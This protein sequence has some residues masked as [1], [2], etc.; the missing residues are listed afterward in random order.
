MIMRNVQ[1]F[2]FFRISFSYVIFHFMHEEMFIKKY[3]ADNIKVSL[4]DL[5]D[6]DEKFLYSNLHFKGLIKRMADGHSKLINEN[7]DLSAITADPNLQK[8]EKTIDT[9][10][11][12]KSQRPFSSHEV[13]TMY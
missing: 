6:Q 4:N 13:M 3:F 11:D 7:F 8:L 5:F 9:P 12:V 2:N 10:D 1:L